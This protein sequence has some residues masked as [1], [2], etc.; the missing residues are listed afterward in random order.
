METIIT[1]ADNPTTIPASAYNKNTDITEITLLPDTIT[2]IGEAA[3]LGCTGLTTLTIPSNITQLDGVAFANCTNL[4]EIIIESTVPAKL[5]E[6]VFEN[7]TCN[8]YV[9]EGTADLYKKSSG[10]S[11]YADR[12]TE[13]GEVTTKMELMGKGQI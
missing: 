3:F 2:S 13:G 5:G 8:I 7:T 12:I 9:P 1:F 6:G 10:W 11:E 4:N